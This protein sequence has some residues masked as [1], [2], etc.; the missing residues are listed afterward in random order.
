[1][2]KHKRK[3]GIPMRGSLFEQPQ[4]LPVGG[5]LP[6]AAL[7]VPTPALHRQGQATSEAAITKHKD[8]INGRSAAIYQVLAT[9]GAGGSIPEDVAHKTGMDLIDVRRA[10]H[11]LK[12]RRLIEA[13][14][15]VWQNDKGNDCEV[16]RV[17]I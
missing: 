9:Y 4:P 7:D 6:P 13:T 3:I 1:M 10:F 11:A 16:W 14:G 12:K 17:R 8:A 2:A 15:G 5:L